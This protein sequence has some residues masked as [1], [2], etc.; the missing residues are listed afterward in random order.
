MRENAECRSFQSAGLNK[1]M[2]RKA[3]RRSLRIL[4]GAVLGLILLSL[5]AT[6][7][8]QTNQWIWIG[9][10]SSANQPTS[11]VPGGRNDTTSWTD[12]SGS[13]WFYGGWI[14]NGFTTSFLNDLWEF[15]PASKT[16]TEVSGNSTAPASCQT[17][18]HC[19]YSG[20]YGTLGVASSSN[21]PGGRVEA[22]GWSD[23]DGNVWLFGGQGFDSAGSLGE[24]NDLWKFSP[25]SGQW[26]WMGGS[27]VAGQ[28]GTYGTLGT[29]AAA[30]IPGARAY[31]ASVV[32]SKGYVWLFAGDGVDST[33][34]WSYLND[35][36]RLDLTTLQWTWMGGSSVAGNSGQQGVYGTRGVAAATNSPGNREL[37]GFGVDQNDNLWL[38]GGA[39]YDP[40]F[41]SEFY[42][43][44]WEFNTSTLQWTWV[45]GSS[46]EGPCS[47][48]GS[49]RL[50]RLA[51]SVRNTEHSGL[52]Q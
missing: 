30:N 23:R 34:S 43:D 6:A 35:L 46:T 32:D 3:F 16:W 1:P 29:P 8:G 4:H 2:N 48:P 18:Q 33:G 9:G 47:T 11:G 7:Y 36:W 5:G 51:R 17:Q 19:G 24:M 20:V 42:N 40:S 38:F 10:S 50:L 37:V 28:R 12:R 21:F 22:A 25:S 52:R 31:P 49:W 45:A 14:T 13:F 44:L 26:A 27:K 41:R 15:N 39:G